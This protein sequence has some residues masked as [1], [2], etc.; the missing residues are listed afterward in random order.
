MQQGCWGDFIFVL[1][2]IFDVFILNCLEKDLEQAKA[3]QLEEAK[4]KLE[5]G[6]NQSE[7]AEEDTCMQDADKMAERLKNVQQ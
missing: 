5:A 1:R 4:K 6:K 3:K 2:A 7:A